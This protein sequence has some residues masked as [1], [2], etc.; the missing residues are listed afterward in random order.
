MIPNSLRLSYY[1]GK[2]RLFW[3]DT[4]PG[5]PI[6]RIGERI[7]MPL[8]NDVFEVTGILHTYPADIPGIVNHIFISVVEI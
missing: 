8:G 7:K 2:N 5:S 1:L 4:F 6:P 3:V